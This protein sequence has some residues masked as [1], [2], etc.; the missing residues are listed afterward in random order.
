MLFN[1]RTGRVPTFLDGQE[2]FIY[3]VSTVEKVVADGHRVL[4]TDRHA[5]MKLAHFSSDLAELKS[6]DWPTIQSNDFSH[7]PEDPERKDRKAAEFLIHRFVSLTSMLGI[8]VYSQKWKDDCD[9]ILAKGGVAL[10]V[11]VHPSWYF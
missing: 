7:R 4:F 6:L 3:F 9:R 11:K 1:I 5:K 10:K 2:P 8:G